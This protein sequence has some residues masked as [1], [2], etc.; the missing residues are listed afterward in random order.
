MMKNV[1]SNMKNDKKARM[2]RGFS[3]AEVIVALAVVVIVSAAATSLIVSHAKLEATTVEMVTAA[4]IAE[5]AIECYRYAGKNTGEGAPTF[6]ELFESTFV[7]ED[8]FTMTGNVATVK[9]NGATYFVTLDDTSVVNT[10]TVTVKDADN[11]VL[12][13]QSY[14][15]P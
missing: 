2:R 12:I 14:K 5:N 11:E 15:R 7:G 8:S 4:N 13:T 3:V 6:T 10:L 1:A 9:V